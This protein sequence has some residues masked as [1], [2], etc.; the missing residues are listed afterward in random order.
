MKNQPAWM[1]LSL[2]ALTFA[3]GT[4]AAQNNTPPPGAETAAV[5][6][7]IDRAGAALARGRSPGDLLA[8][9]VFVPAHEWP[10]FRELIRERGRG[11]ELTIVTP[12]EP[13][14]RL[15]VNARIVDGAG[16][17]VAEAEVYVY[18]TSAEG[19]Y[20][21]RAPHYA[22]MEGDRRHARLFGYLRTGADGRFR[23]YT[24]R[25]SGY[26][27]S[28]LPAHIHVEI[29]AG[30]KAVITEI[31]FDNAP[32]LPAEARERWLREGFVIAPVATAADG[33]QRVEVELRLR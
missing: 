22:G 3:A 4:A 10:R 26:P 13:G 27:G 6:E 20:S 11:S 24:V 8:D 5:R 30:E 25:P 28:G 17:P 18:Q 21:D 14:P 2:V 23:L 9:P 33:S 19:W 29:R 12:A 32:R 15:E 31:L 16:K 7:L 1:P